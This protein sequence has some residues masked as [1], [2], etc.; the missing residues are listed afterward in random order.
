MTSPR[1]NARPS[2]AAPADSGR[3]APRPAG[4]APC[5]P[6]TAPASSLTTADRS[7]RAHTRRYGRPLR[8]SATWNEDADGSFLRELAECQRGLPSPGHDGPCSDWNCSTSDHMS[9]SI[10]T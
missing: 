10:S 8:E 5:P 7:P 4:P 2:W 1:R 6:L 3:A 9:S